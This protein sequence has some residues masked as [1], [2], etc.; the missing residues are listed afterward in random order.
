MSNRLK[1]ITV[2]QN[3]YAKLKSLG[4]AGDSFNDVITEILDKVIP[5]SEQ[6]NQL[7]G[8]QS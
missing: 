2:D 5:E 7:E 1:H 8:E 6:R 4:Q 3:N